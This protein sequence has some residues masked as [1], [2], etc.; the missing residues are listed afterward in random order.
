MKTLWLMILYLALLAVPGL[1][2]AE[3]F[4]FDMGTEQS[5]LRPGFTRV[6]ARSTYDKQAGYGWE[7]GEGLQEHYKYYDRKWEYD[8]G[9]GSERP[10]P[11]Y[12]NQ[13]TCDSVWSRQP[14]TL[15]IDAAPGE[16]MVWLL[17][18][19]SAGSPRDYHQFDVAVRGGKQT[20]AAT[21]KIPGP[22]I[23]ERRRLR[24]KADGPRI[25]IDLQPRTDWVLASVVVFPVNEEA[26]V[27]AEFLDALEKEI[28][29]LPPDVA[30]KWQETKVVDDR[31]MPELSQADRQRGYAI[32]ARHWSEVVYPQTVPRAEE[33]NPKLATFASLGEYEP[34]TFTV[35]PLVDL[36]SARVVASDLRCGDA[37]IPAANIEVRSVRNMLVR[38]NY[39]TFFSYHEAPDVLEARGSLDLARGR[40]QRF[41][42]TVKTPDDAAPGVYQGK[43][44]FQSAS[45]EPADVSLQVRVLPI[46]LKENPEH[47]YGMYYRDPLSNIA[48]GNSPEANAYFIRKAE[49]ERR[50]M[51]AHG[52]NSHISQV[53][54]LARDAEGNWTMDGAETERRIALDRKYGLADKPLVVSFPVG[55]WYER[56]V[57][58]QGLGSHLRLV[59]DDV[60]Q[61]FY[62]EVTKMVE[63]IEREKKNYDWPEFLYYPIDEPSTAEK[64]VRFMVGVLKAIKQAPGARTYVTADPSHEQ[65]EPMWPY[66]DVWCCQ[67]FVF[68]H[69]KIR[70]L[71]R[72]KNIEF[73]CYPNHISGENDHTPIRGARMTWGFGF[74]KSG[75]RTLIPWI[76][77]SSSGDP[78]NYLDGSSMDF[79]NR[80]TPDGEPIP[81]AMWEA[82][83]EG[84]DDGR[85]LYTLER[86]IAEKANRGGRAAQI[87]A[88]AKKEVEFVW[89]AIE[90]QEKYKYD[91]LWSG[92]DFD[93]YRWL[94]ASKILEL[95]R[96][97]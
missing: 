21:V 43:V 76:Y 79:F 96:V 53:S 19:F 47:I 49:L 12:T 13:I 6:T 62:D 36:S 17:S 77:Q 35:L 68:G 41:W 1:A 63:A 29:F 88:E 15:L 75:F 87:A 40:N 84:I 85:Y 78:W 67:P 10:S 97:E 82:Y 28:T 46:R 33:L 2:G 69:E 23:F 8:E 9:R 55:W 26:A 92:P 52:M 16:Y 65:F 81:V 25:S 48:S 95:E 71:S 44:T 73:W 57:D 24:V 93:A 30:E 59:R 34:V 72:E 86:L 58:K 70:R 50:D 45:T 4:R 83:R 32:F 3:V 80:S 20:A 14:N 64:S 60:P 89:N 18:G 74:W 94:L 56:L 22:Y 42:I 11:I 37:V 5:E 91:G 39:S 27:R 38:P 90:V 61:S 54:G 7:S 51:V 31:P 66:V